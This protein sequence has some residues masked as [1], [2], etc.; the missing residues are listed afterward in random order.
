MARFFNVMASG[1]MMQQ[2]P[3]TEFMYGAAIKT[4]LR[5]PNRSSA[6]L[7]VWLR[8]VNKLDGGTLNDA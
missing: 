6:Q 7:G 4:I 3:S 2:G 1:L 5:E 8:T